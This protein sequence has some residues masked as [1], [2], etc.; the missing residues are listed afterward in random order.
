MCAYRKAIL[1][2]GMQ[3]HAMSLLTI[4][5]ISFPFGEK[6]N[7]S[8][9]LIFF[10]YKRARNITLFMCIKYRCPV[11]YFAVKQYDESETLQSVHARMSTRG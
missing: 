5:S 8:R 2:I 3:L 4:W 6:T 1:M 9:V 10:F 7:A 11:Q